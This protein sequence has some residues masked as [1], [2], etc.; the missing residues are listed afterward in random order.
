MVS[1]CPAVL[2][3][4][5]FGTNFSDLVIGN[6]PLKWGCRTARGG[7][8]LAAGRKR[9]ATRSQGEGTESFR[10]HLQK[11]GI[12]QEISK[13]VPCKTVG[14]GWPGNALGRCPFPPCCYPRA[15][16]HSSP[17]EPRAS[18]L[19]YSHEANEATQ[20]DT[21]GRTHRRSQ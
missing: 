9:P 17:P 13:T 16:M 1:W 4:T 19:V 21:G 10:E 6:T 11:A 2:R 15:Y 3:A 7:V 14:S 8:L 12:L 5:D 18:R 20:T